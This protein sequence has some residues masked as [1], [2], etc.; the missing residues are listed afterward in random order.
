MGNIIAIVV[1]ST[2]ALLLIEFVCTIVII[3]L[4]D[5][6]NKISTRY[7]TAYFTAILCIIFTMVVVLLQYFRIAMPYIKLLDQ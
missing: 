5:N 3:M 2:I 1:L 4:L 6:I 7:R